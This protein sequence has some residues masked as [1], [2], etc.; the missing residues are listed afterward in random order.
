MSK[1]SPPRCPNASKKGQSVVQLC[2]TMENVKIFGVASKGKHE[3]LKESI[4]HL[5]ERGTD[6][7]G[8]VRK[9]SP[10]GIDVIFDCNC[11]DECNRGYNLLKPMGKYILFGSSNYVTGETKSFFNAAKSWWQVGKI[12][13]IKLFY[14][15][16]NIGGLNL[17]H[18][19]YHQDGAAYVRE[20][21]NKVFDLWKQQKIKPVV[22]SS[23]ALED[24]SEAMQKLHDRKNIGKLVLDLAL[25]PK[26]KPP[27]PV[28][29]KKGNSIDK[30]DKKKEEEGANGVADQQQ[31]QPQ[32]D[33]VA[34]EN[35][36]S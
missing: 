14:E 34:K 7:V 35:N 31:Q 15:N 22:D 21:V 36:A 17:R 20:I 23:W 27:T 24:V 26:P 10:E 5:L 12:S 1:S 19:L 25:E 29:G 3:A 28:K 11:G 9:V 8:E 32:D 2:R 18:L 33:G 13:P 6:Y 16:K 30:E 4:D